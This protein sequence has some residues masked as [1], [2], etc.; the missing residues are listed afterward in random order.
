M[1]FQGFLK[2]STA[3]DV[4]IGP[5]VD[6]DDGKT[7]ETGL[8]ISQADVKLSKNGQAL[9]QK[10]DNTSAAAD[11][12]GYYNCELDATDTNTCG[13]LTLIVHESGAL[14]IRLD[15]HVIEEAIYDSLYAASSA[16]FDSNQRTNVGR[17]LSQA[18]TLSTGNKPD[19]NIDE[20]SDDTTAPGNLELMYDGTGYA[21]GTT[22]LDVNTVQISADTTA[23]DNAEAFFDGTGYAGGTI[24]LD[25][26]VA[27]WLASAVTLSPTNL[28]DVNIAEIS[29]DSDAADNLELITELGRGVTIN[30]TGGTTGQDADDLVDD[31]WDESL[32]GNDHNTRHTAGWRLRRASGGTSEATVHSGTAQGGSANTIIFDTDALT[33]NNIYRGN[34]VNITGGTGVGQTGQIFAYTGS[35]YTATMSK[36]WITTPD[37][38]STFDVIA[39]STAINADEGVAQAGTVN[40]ITLASTASDDDDVYNDALLTIASGTG[41]GQTVIVSDYDGTTKIA[42]VSP[43][44]TSVP[45]TTSVYAVIPDSQ[46]SGD[47]T[48]SAPSA[49][50]VADAVWN[51]TQSEHT[52]SGTTGESLNTAGGYTTA[53]TAAAI[54]DAVWDETQ[55]EHVAV[56]STGES[57]NAAG[58]FGTPPTAAAVADAVWD[59][60]QADHLT[61]G[62]TGYKLNRS[63]RYSRI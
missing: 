3:V 42:T 38:T 53:P 11:A 58:D 26:N 44:F 28:P 45:D 39:S 18:V 55:S 63:D 47:I 1:A 24:K 29:D 21:G 59:E 48:F 17:W 14:P 12:N 49:E 30:A 6:E 8:T 52:T 31:V 2:Q 16:G 25:V 7:A 20:I 46:V 33:T 5:F 43:N 40:T 22:K 32:R 37:A 10:N 50:E 27:T 62:T 9:A 60:V 56:G 57:V 15:Y 36:D 13:Q 51:E 4:L 41:S 19:V 54:A 23:A 61:E 35:T 34:L